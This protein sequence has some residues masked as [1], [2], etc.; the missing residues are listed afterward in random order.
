MERHKASFTAMMAGLLLASA[1][2]A[3]AVPA[4]PAIDLAPHRAVYDMSLKSALAGSNVADIRGRLVFDFEGSACAGYSLKSRLVTQVVDRE[5]NS[6]VTDLRST[7]WENADGDK[8]RFDSSQYVDQRLSDQVAGLAAKKKKSGGIEVKLDKP[9]RKS[10]KFAA[11]AMFPTQHSIAI[12]VAAQQGSEILKANIYDGSEKGDRLY[13][14]TT[15]IG[16]PSESAATSVAETV[17]NTERLRGMASW[18]VSISYYEPVA[19]PA[20][21]EGLPSYEL[22]FRLFSNGVSRDLVIDYGNFSIRGV[23]SRIDF[24]KPAACP[25]GK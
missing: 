14:T 9:E 25:D 6:T 15:F 11:G 21:D 19:S 16:K 7:T 1:A 8:F 4:A 5:G 13:E 24:H 17:A 22:S 12:L 2:P 3:L 18:P 20:S 10:L 23:L